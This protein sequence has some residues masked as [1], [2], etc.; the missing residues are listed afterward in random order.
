CLSSS[1][2]R[3]CCSSSLSLFSCGQQLLAFYR[4][5]F[6]KLQ[7][8]EAFSSKF[9]KAAARLYAQLQQQEQAAQH[10]RLQQQQLQQQQLQLSSLQHALLQSLTLSTTVMGRMGVLHLPLLQTVTKIHIFF[11]QT[12]SAMGASQLLL[13][14][15][16][17]WKQQ[18]GDAQLR[19]FLRWALPRLF[20]AVREL[21]APLPPQQALNILAAAAQ[22][23]MRDAK[24]ISY[25]LWILS[26]QSTSSSSSSSSSTQQ[27]Q[28]QS[29]GSCRAPH[30]AFAAQGKSLQ[31]TNEVFHDL[32]PAPSPFCYPA[33]PPCPFDA[34]KCR[35]LLEGLEA[36][37]LTALVGF[38][39]SLAFWTP[40]AMHIVYQVWELL[41]GQLHDMRA[42]QI[43][44][45]ALAFRDWHFRDWEMPLELPEPEGAATAAAGGAAAAAGGAAAAAGGSGVRGPALCL[46]EAN[47]AAA[48]AAALSPRLALLLAWK[49]DL[50][51]CCIEA[52]GRHLNYAAETWG[53]LRKARL[54]QH[55][56]SLGLMLPH[57]DLLQQQQQ[58]LQRV[59]QQ[60]QQ[61]VQQP[62]QQQQLLL[63]Q[64]VQ[65]QQ[66]QRPSLVLHLPIRGDLGPLPLLELTSSSKLGAP[67][68]DTSQGA[69]QRG[70]PWGAP[71]DAASPG[72]PPAW[73]PPA[74][75]PTWGAPSGGPS[76]G[77][78]PWSPLWGAS[79]GGPPEERCAAEQLG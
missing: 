58:Q 77:A 45:L 14:C 9:A 69:P 42:A 2:L 22:I 72:G 27:Q 71:R 61:Q 37:Q 54:L 36:Q 34:A 13:C 19:A 6:F 70:L 25:L 31:Y 78:P 30:R 33:M 24:T 40:T 26:G 73:G 10:T 28:Q 38:V 68:T 52:M 79:S 57:L 39:D 60:Q 20:N 47:A 21:A 12:I 50:I 18:E 76:W 46:S 65:Q 7:L 48:A 8:L 63:Q 35:V 62:Q 44:T 59:L 66:Q 5:R 15:S 16:Q 43:L 74:G 67:P 49:E 64:H 17:F 55:A 75:G 23:Q 4:L 53:C 32:N 41:Q 1:A 29:D 56:V 51:C 3:R 11:P